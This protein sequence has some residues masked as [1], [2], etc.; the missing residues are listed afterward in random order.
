MDSHLPDQMRAMVYRGANDLRVETVAVPAISKEELLVRV[1]VCG[2]CPTDIKKIQHATVPP[3]RIFGHETAG[4]IVR[5]GADVKG[6]AEGDRVAL[7]HHVPCMR[8]HA[9]RHKAFAQCAI[10][11]K[12]GVTAG[13]EPA[14][15][16][17]AEYVRVLPFVFPGIVRIPPGNTLTEGALLEPV[18]TVL[19]GVRRLGLL[20]GDRV[21]VVG[22]GP[23]G[24]LFTRILWLEGVQVVVSDLIPE[25]LRRAGEFGATE[26]FEAGGPDFENRL[27]ESAGS[28]FDAV[29]LAAPADELMP[30]AMESLRG[31]G[32]ILLFAH[33]RK[34]A[35]RDVDLGEIC[36][37]E[38]DVLGSYS[39]DITLQE[40]V[41]RLVFSRE[42]D[43]RELVSHRFRLENAVEA[44][45]VAARPHQGTLKVVVQPAEML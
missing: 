26:V 44:V 40:E 2:V 19:K 41:S 4:V 13:F 37:S 30:L 39:S 31:G 11:Q 21:W 3:P 9:C 18:N 33:T 27:R 20:Q 15:G 5:V 12:T 34:G 17:F 7:H 6:Y 14:G 43:V 28:G 42:L 38:K 32:K 29:V 8:C 1:G 36:V 25:R 24:L 35:M 16:G 22:Q 10:Y 23:V 45:G